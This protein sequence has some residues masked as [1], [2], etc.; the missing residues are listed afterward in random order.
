MVVGSVTQ[1]SPVVAQ[2]GRQDPAAGSGNP[3]PAP[4]PVSLSIQ[5]ATAELSAAQQRVQQHVQNFIAEHDQEAHFSVDHTTGMT[6]VQI[7]NRAS[8]ELVRQIPTE[9]VVRIARF[10]DAQSTFV[11][12]KA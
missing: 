3:L 11:N 2:P 8:G 6:I 7:V 1:Q 12:V 5:D 4:A 10:L 9:E